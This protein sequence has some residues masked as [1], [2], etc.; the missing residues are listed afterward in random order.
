V[1]SRYFKDP[2]EAEE[3]MLLAKGVIDLVERKLNEKK[4]EANN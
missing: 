3:A 4:E 2:E 1:P